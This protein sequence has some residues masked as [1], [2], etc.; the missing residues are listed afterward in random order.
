LEPNLIQRCHPIAVTVGPD[1]GGEE[2]CVP[3]IA[4]I[5]RLVFACTPINTYISHAA[6]HLSRLSDLR[7]IMQHVQVQSRFPLELTCTYS[8]VVVSGTG[9]N[10]V[11]RTD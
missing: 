5:S 3:V 6:M 4:Q 9:S 10:S 1:P 7:R 2:D 11:S 8:I